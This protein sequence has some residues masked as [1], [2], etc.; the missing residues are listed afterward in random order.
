MLGQTHT[1]ILYYEILND[2]FLTAIIVQI[3]DMIEILPY[4]C[5]DTISKSATMWSVTL[6]VRPPAVYDHISLVPWVVL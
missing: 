4:M 2:I 6:V 1:E 3:N 5:N